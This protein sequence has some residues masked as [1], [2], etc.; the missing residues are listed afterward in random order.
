MTTDPTPA[1]LPAFETDEACVEAMA[2]GSEP[3]L[4]LLYD[5]HVAVV[6]GLA[7]RI[8]GNEELAKEATAAAFA[9]AWGGAARYRGLRGS[10][11]GW[12]TTIVRLRALELVRSSERASLQATSGDPSPLAAALPEDTQRALSLVFFEGLNQQEVAAR[13]DLPL[14]TVRRHVES[15]MRALRHRREAR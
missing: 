14:E 9:Q 13:L 11:Q 7:L 4:R 5:R 8:T 12:L 3:A 10:V 15:G 1:Q 2:R 6:Y